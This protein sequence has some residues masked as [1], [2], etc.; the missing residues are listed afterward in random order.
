MKQENSLIFE[1]LNTAQYQAVK[2]IEGPS[3]IIAGAGSGKT[4]VLTCRIANILD[5]GY[6]PG[7]ILALTFTNKASK[8]MKARIA[9]LV[10]EAKA[11]RLWMG[12]FH[13][14]F[15]RFLREEAQLL[16]FPKTFTVYDTTDSRSVIKACI[17]ELQLDDKT[18]KPNEV[19]SR[20][21]MAKNNLV[22]AEA[23]MRN[24]VLIQN[25]TIA[26]KP[27]VCEIYQLYAKKCKLSGAMDF[28]DI[29]IF[30]NILFR[31]FPDALKRIRERFKF[32][33]VDEY[34]D[35]NFS[36]YLIIK[37]L[38]QEHRNI[39]VVGDDAQ[40]IYSFRGARI[41]NILNFKKDYPETKEYRLEQ[42]YRST[43]TIVNAA[44]SLI[45]KNKMQLKKKCFS[46]H[47]EGEQIELINAFTEQEEGFM[48]ASSIMEQIHKTKEPYSNFAILYRTNAQSRVIEESLR[49]KNMPYKIFAG[50]SF[51]DRAEVKDMLA[52]LRLI[53]NEK[54]DEAFKRII[55]FP[56]RGIG[57][58][59]FGKL[60]EAAN[61]KGISLSEAVKGENLEEFG[62][63]GA[64]IHKIKNFITIIEQIREKLIYTT[65]YDIA[66]EVNIRFGIINFLKQD[67]TLEAQS[68]V[69]NIEELFNSIKEFV[70]EGE[71]EYKE[72]I[73]DGYEAP[74]VTLD[75]YLENVSLLSDMDGKEKEEDKN[76]IALMTVHSS[77]GLEFPYV[78][79]IGM[80]ENL[81]PSQ[82][83]GGDSE[84]EMEEERRLF[85]VAITRAEKG[86]K[87]SFAHSRIK[88]GSH[89]SNE[90]SRFLKEI[91]K[92][93]ILNPITNFEDDIRTKIDNNNN[94][95]SFPDR[96]QYGQRKSFPQNNGRIQR[97]SDVQ[98]IQR[99]AFSRPAQARP[100]NS[101]FV[102]DSPSKMAAG[103]TIEHERFGLGIIISIEGDPTN[104]KAIVDFKEG[105]RKT[106]LLKFA[107]IRII[108]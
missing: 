2:N 26:K 99:P 23:Y 98:P 47:E 49:R 44:N 62:L 16:G 78:Y 37:K 36:Q 59:S 71:E 7:C 88:W 43:Q 9:A 89:V 18:Y 12:T 81:F 52:Y 102:A 75:L 66:I 41:E 85:Y 97:N 17:K 53:S 64:V 4:K 42:N 45:D 39:S 67:T 48:V 68:R 31:D 80:E 51:Y 69:E 8:E 79:I 84:Q 87:L 104:L 15:I 29:L 10:G 1:G 92:S 3:L 63:K 46:K 106:L 25:D 54:D 103:Q 77:K 100:A 65:A 6:E 28:D 30:T 61:T 20:I 5:N 24:N 82:S 27:R 83:R 11:R 105:G 101:N 13:S 21:S 50:H 86:V 107:K 19:H 108:L 55:N 96:V 57:E 40:S 38:S 56:T 60:K 95:D 14:I 70:E 91:D 58:T 34:Q 33:M 74:I 72:L 76:K 22:T 35:T 90:P 32:I 93:Y 73:A 94:N